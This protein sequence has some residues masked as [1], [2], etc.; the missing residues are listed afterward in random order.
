M[1]RGAI[2]QLSA[3]QQQL[4][5]HVCA[6]IPS[7]LSRTVILLNII[8]EHSSNLCGVAQYCVWL[9]KLLYARSLD[10]KVCF[11]YTANP[12]NYAP[13]LGKPSHLFLYKKQDLMII[14]LVV[15]IR[16]Y[17][18]NSRKRKVKALHS[19]LCSCVCPIQRWRTLWRPTLTRRRR[20]LSPERPSSTAVAP[21][22]KGPS[23]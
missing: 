20:V 16:N 21:N 7:E 2:C 4:F 14:F 10:V 18:I 17:M 3:G 1:F 22:P 15:A 19:H 8:S 6:F 9:E 5:C 12:E 13:S 11:T 23:V